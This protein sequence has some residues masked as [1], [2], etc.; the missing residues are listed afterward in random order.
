MILARPVHWSFRQIR[1]AECFGSGFIHLKNG[2]VMMVSNRWVKKVAGWVVLTALVALTGCANMYVDGT[3]REIASS[4]FKVPDP[5]HPVQMLFEFQTKG[6]PN[7][8]ATEFLK[9]RVTDQVKASGL[10]SSVTDSPVPGGALL[11]ITLDNVPLT[12]D[13]F[14]KGFVTGLTFG[15]AGSK[16]SDGYVCT[17]RYSNGASTQPIVKQARHAIHTT[18]GATSVPQ[19]VTKAE[20]AT[21]AVTLMTTQILS[22]ALNDLSYDVAFN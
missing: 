19:N 11:S 2:V 1:G 4:S 6:A 3:T 13:V 12:D 22:N 7:A 20:N 10:F 14:V 9:T 5:L 21:A 16:V 17:V 18:I 8:R 15:L